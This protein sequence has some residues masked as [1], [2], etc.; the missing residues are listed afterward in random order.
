MTKAL[1]CGLCGTLRSFLSTGAITMC[2][3]GSLTGWWE[4][5]RRGIARLFSPRVD[6][7]DFGRI[8]GMHNGFLRDAV[9][10]HGG[11]PVHRTLHDHHTDA[12]GYLFDKSQR[13]CWAIVIAPGESNDTRWASDE[14]YAAKQG[15]D[16]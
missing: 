3:C 14:E 13:G 12:P 4:D 10:E 15:D 9:Q 6:A 1:Y 2:E 11:S 8:I 16:A 7:R 5:P